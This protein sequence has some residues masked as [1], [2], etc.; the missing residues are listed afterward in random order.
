MAIQL[1]DHSKFSH[2]YIR[3]RSE[4]YDRDLVYQASGMKV[5]FIGLPLFLD[6]V[7]IYKEF[8]IE[9]SEETKQKVVQFAID[10]VGLPYSLGAAIGILAVKAAALFGRK[11]KNPVSQRG[12]FCSELAAIILKDYT[13]A[14][15]TDDDVKRM[16]PSDVYDFLEAN[17]QAV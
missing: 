12:Y 14:A 11:I 8:N 6:H 3:F 2:A 4:S 5:N 1:V 10:H 15:L 7:N 17:Y 13:G 16:T 9:V